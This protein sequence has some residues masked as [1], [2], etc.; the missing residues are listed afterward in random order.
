MLNNAKVIIL[1]FSLY[2]STT[3]ISAQ[4][5]P[6]KIVYKVNPDKSVNFN[7]E[8]TDPGNYTIILN[9][10]SLDNA[11]SPNKDYTVKNYSGS[12]LTLTPIIKENSISFSYSYSSIKGKLNPKY[13]A[14]FVYLMPAKK[15]TKVKV[16]D[17]GFLGARYFG[18]TTP[19]DWKV[20]RFST[21]NQD[22][23]TAVRK[24]IVMNITE[25]EE[26]KETENLT[27]SSKINTTTIEHLDGT[28]ATYKGFKKGSFAVK[29]GDTVFPGTALGLNSKSNA[30]GMYG[31]TL[32]IMY[33]K[34][35][36]L[37]S[38]KSQNIQNSKSLYGFVNPNFYT[39]DNASVKLIAKQEYTAAT[40]AEIVQKELTKKELKQKIK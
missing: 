39:A 34:S 1:L 37:E 3:K 24:G 38:R 23:V 18:N 9:F 8:K 6:V 16:A 40:P 14:D 29:I 19:D 33:L 32:S 20:L 31:S 26:P 28:L 12:L 36:D 17:V 22:T 11:V 10:K 13:M 27:Y 2:F 4:D 30:N 35:I 5:G 7:Y 15:G 25:E 21:E